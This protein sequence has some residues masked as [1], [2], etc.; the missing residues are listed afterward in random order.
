MGEHPA[1][2]VILFIGGIIAILGVVGVVADQAV[3]FNQAVDGRSQSVGGEMRTDVAVLNDPGSSSTSYDDA[4]G[5]LT[6]YVENTGSRG[7]PP[8]PVA[9]DLLVDGTYV[10]N[11]SMAVLD[12]E[13]WHPGA[14]ARLR[15]N[16]SL[17]ANETHRVVVR[18]DGAR[19]VYEF[20]TYAALT[21]P[22]VRAARP[23]A[24]P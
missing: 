2:F 1:A 19:S 12:G 13:D 16:V 10:T 22:S 5:T 24:A 6:L 4:N 15:A 8:D 23:A 17:A 21:A 9:V 20:D 18:V 7:L 3:S 14:V 11:V